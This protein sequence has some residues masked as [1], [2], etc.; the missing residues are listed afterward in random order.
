MQ[1]P[2]SCRRLPDGSVVSRHG[3][4]RVGRA[5][6]MQSGGWAVQIGGVGRRAVLSR[7]VVVDRR[8]PRRAHRVV[9]TGAGHDVAP[10]GHGA[11]LDGLRGGRAGR[12]RAAW[13][14]PS[15][16]GPHHRLF[17]HR[18]PA[19]ITAADRPAPP[20]RDDVAGTNQVGPGDRANS[21]GLLTVRAE[22]LAHSLA[23][24]DAVLSNSADADTLATPISGP[25][26]LERAQR[27]SR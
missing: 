4:Y 24:L 9:P 21:E 25:P 15:S 16:P 10:G 11:A 12:C 13:A 20:G 3:A 14:P 22:K 1:H 23:R 8:R 5:R 17:H 2:S 27:R 7:A 19:A 26:A 6:G 18:R